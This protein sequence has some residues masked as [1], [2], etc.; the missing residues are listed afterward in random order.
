MTSRLPACMRKRAGGLVYLPAVHG[1]LCK[2]RRF[3]HEQE[4]EKE[5][6]SL[7]N[8]NGLS[9]DDA[10]T[11][12]LDDMNCLNGQEEHC[13]S[14]AGHERRPKQASQKVSPDR[15]E[16]RGRAVG[17]NAPVVGVDAGIGP[18][19]VSA[20]PYNSQIPTAKLIYR[21]YSNATICKFS[22]PVTGGAYHSAR[23]VTMCDCND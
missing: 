10:R 17:F 9:H 2:K 16:R 8:M 23:K 15:Y 6:F 11:C 22:C 21:S 12:A 7:K 4:A 19:K 13:S 20:N 18:Y 5:P 1:K 3:F 14:P